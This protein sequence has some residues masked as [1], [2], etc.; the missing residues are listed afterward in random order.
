MGRDDISPHG[1]VTQT[2]RWAGMVPRPPFEGRVIEPTEKSQTVT[3]EV[4]HGDTEGT[5]MCQSLR[6]ILP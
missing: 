6:K 1:Q 5:E 3:E 2:I 4:H